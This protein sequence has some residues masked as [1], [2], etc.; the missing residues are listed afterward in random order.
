MKQQSYNSKGSFSAIAEPEAMSLR[1]IP[2]TTSRQPGLGLLKMIPK[3]ARFLLFITG[4]MGC[5][6]VPPSR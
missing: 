3:E 4:C 1:L 6:E 2:L 5:A